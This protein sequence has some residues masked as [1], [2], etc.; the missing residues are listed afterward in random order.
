MTTAKTIPSQFTGAMELKVISTDCATGTDTVSATFTK[1]YV[2][3]EL[4]RE[5]GPAVLLDGKP[6]QWWVHGCQFSEEEFGHFLAK[7]ALKEK[8]ES[9]LG[10]KGSSSRGK[11]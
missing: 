2:G 5:N 8:L 10:E 4:H 7:K 9:N 6:H 3:G 11:I 1:H